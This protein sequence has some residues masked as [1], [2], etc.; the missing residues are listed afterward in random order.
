M[1][2]DRKRR[3]RRHPI[4]NPKGHKSHM[5][6]FRRFIK[7]KGYRKAF[8]DIIEKQIKKLNEELAQE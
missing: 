3:I 1:G 2:H 6:G 5:S 7:C 4:F 8:E